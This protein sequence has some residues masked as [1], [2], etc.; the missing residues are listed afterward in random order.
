MASQLICFGS[1][2]SSLLTN[3]IYTNS[4]VLAHWMFFFRDVCVEN[5][6][7]E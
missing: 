4:Y 6:K 7:N 1:P 3:A 2:E 5:G